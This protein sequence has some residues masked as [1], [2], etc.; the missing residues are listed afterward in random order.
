MLWSYARF[1]FGLPSYLR[2]RIT[3]EQA[4]TILLRRL[5]Q[6]EE[7]FLRLVERG[8]G[9]RPGSPY[10]WLLE[11]AGAE[12]GDLRAMVRAD[13]LEATLRALRRAGV[14]VTFEEFKGAEPIVRDGRVL[15]VGARDFDNPYPG[16]AYQVETGGTTGAGRRVT[17]DL[18][19]LADRAPALLL[20]DSA[21][22]VLGLPA[23]LWF[24][25]LPGS[26]LNSVLSRIPYG[27]VPERWF[28]SLRNEDF[29]P[30]LRFRAANRATLAIARLTGTPIPRP[31]PLRLEDAVVLARWAAGARDRA[32]GAIVRTTVSRALRMCLAARDAGLDLGAVVVSGG[33]EPPTAAKA[34][35][36]QRS[37]ARLETN[38]FFAE[39]GPVGLGCARPT[40][41]NDQHFLSDH[42]AVI[43]HP[44]RVPAADRTVDAFHFTTLLPSAPKLL[45]NVESDDYGIVESR[46]CG[47]PLGEIGYATHMREI[48]SFRK[49]TGEGVTLVGNEM[50]RT[51]EEILPARFGGTPL[52]YQ[53]VEEEDDRG[54]TRV[55]LLA[56]PHLEIADEREVL[57][58]VLKALSQGSDTARITAAL[59]QSA[60]SLQL[61]R[62][63]PRWTA[64]GKLMPLDLGA[65][66]DGGQAASA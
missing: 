49:L 9:G 17:V 20:A 1:A 57:N 29:R 15:R 4:R 31:E 14:Y 61:R 62:A 44:R 54:F 53:I 6:R 16:G 28:T 24:E 36:I 26:G 58:A 11:R 43:Q 13:G 42:L 5:E 30:A 59:W 52:D 38:Y 10:R 66:R 7:N 35:E 37:G 56:S 12:V 2:R 60:G 48:R 63:A 64:R 46:S 21:H 50:E 51:L 25:P 34:R 32:G 27:H 39:A 23:A 40:G 3:F 47:C 8:I 22:G 41:V 19:H 55:V 65:A 18:H 45:L 33:G